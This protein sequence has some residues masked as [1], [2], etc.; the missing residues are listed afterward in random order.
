MK[1]ARGEKLTLNSQFQI[2]LTELLLYL[3]F[4]VPKTK[5]NKTNGRYL[6]NK[7]EKVK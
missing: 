5:Q 1:H 3:T 4:L 2:K 6:E 7:I